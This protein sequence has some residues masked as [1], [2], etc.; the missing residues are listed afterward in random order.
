MKA[1][2]IPTQK[3]INNNHIM[4]A[5]RIKLHKHDNTRESGSLISHGTHHKSHEK[6][7]TR[8]QISCKAKLIFRSYL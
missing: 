7:S 3:K 5:A 8:A 1:E 2:F 4:E 6:D